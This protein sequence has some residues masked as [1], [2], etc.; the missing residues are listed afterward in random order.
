MKTVQNNKIGLAF[1]SQKGIALLTIMVFLLI[2][3]VIGLSSM[4]TSRLEQQMAGNT[5]WSNIAFQVAE[6]GLIESR[7]NPTWVADVDPAT[8]VSGSYS[9]GEGEPT[10]INYGYSRYFTNFSPLLRENVEEADD[11]GAKR[12]ANFRTA[13]TGDAVEG[14]STTVLATIQ[15]EEGIYIKVPNSDN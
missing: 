1:Q 2:L 5:Q 12:K 13:S 9:P 15:L 10:N 7:R 14:S 8:S 4:S 11:A 3:T 6:T